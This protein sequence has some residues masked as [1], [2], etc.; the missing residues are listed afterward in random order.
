MVL[1]F[2]GQY[3]VT[4]PHYIPNSNGC[5]SFGLQVIS[6][7]VFWLYSFKLA[8]DISSGKKKNFLIMN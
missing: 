3:R 5:G 6:Q 2:S 8:S 1:G 4:N 7:F